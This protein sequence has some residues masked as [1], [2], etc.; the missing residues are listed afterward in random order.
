MVIVDDFSWFTWVSFLHQKS[1]TDQVMINFIKHIELGLRKKVRKIKS[2]NG[3]EF[4][5]HVL[6]SFLVDLGITHK[7]SSP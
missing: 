1:E 5:N 3:S 7:F 2:D 6:D 4:K